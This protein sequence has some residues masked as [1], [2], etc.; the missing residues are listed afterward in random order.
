LGNRG[1]PSFGGQ[2]TL[3]VCGAVLFAANV[4]PT[5]EIVMIGIELP[6]LQLAG[7][8]AVTL[9]LAAVILYYSDFRGARRSAPVN[10]FG[11]VLRGSVITYAV[12]LATAATILWL[13][14]RFDDVGPTAVVGQTVA[15]GVASTLG[16]SAGRLLLHG[17]TGD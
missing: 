12:G 7:L 8:G 11:S 14:G 13:F 15:L 3:A 17:G 6:A 10:G 5:E 9:G 2:L 4:A 16:A 1:R